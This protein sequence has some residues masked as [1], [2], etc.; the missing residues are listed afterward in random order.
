M[1]S[2]GDLGDFTRMSLYGTMEL[3]N[4]RHFENWSHIAPTYLSV[5]GLMPWRFRY[6]GNYNQGE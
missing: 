5:Y 4:K 2:S 6:L 3:G 1:L